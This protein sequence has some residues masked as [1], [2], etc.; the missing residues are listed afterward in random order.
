MLQEHT[1]IKFYRSCIFK[2]DLDEISQA[3]ERAYR[4]MCRTI[5]FPK[6]IDQTKKSDLEKLGFE[7]IKAEINDMTLCSQNEYDAWVISTSDKLQALYQKNGVEL[8]LGHTQKW[9]NMTMK[10]LLCFDNQ[11]ARGIEHLLHVPIDTYVVEE[12]KK[13]VPTAGL[14][15]WS[16]IESAN[17]YTAF[18]NNLRTVI[19]EKQLAESPIIWEFNAWSGHK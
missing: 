15:P 18:Q 14:L 16:K 13:L 10:Y 6:N 7:T 9:I 12:A 11:K 19:L 1:L 4:D 2:R 3:A 8:T 5:R 17:L